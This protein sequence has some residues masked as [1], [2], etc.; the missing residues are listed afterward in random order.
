MKKAIALM[1]VLAM[2]L[3][4]CACGSTSD[5]SKTDASNDLPAQSDKTPDA[6]GTEE[7]NTVTR[8]DLFGEWVNY[9][10]G[11][12]LSI[13]NTEIKY[14]YYSGGSFTTDWTFA[15]LEGDTFSEL[16]LG[17][18]RIVKGE[19]GLQLVSEEYGTFIS[20]D[21]A[22]KRTENESCR[23]GEKGK[24]ALAEISM[25]KYDFAKIIGKE[26]TTR[27]F[28]NDVHYE[29]APD[30]MV[31]MLIYFDLSSLAKEQ[32]NVPFDVNITVDYNNGYLF[33]SLDGNGAYCF[34]DEAN[35][36]Y[37]RYM[38]N[39]G[40]VMELSPLQSGKYFAAIPVAE[41]VSTDTTSPLAVLFEIG[42]KGDTDYTAIRFKVQ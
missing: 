17:E 38:L 7:A 24:G 31:Y 3:A 19:E 35:G 12:T 33:K 36:A 1:V 21:A 16:S 15:S 25:T 26:N 34:V 2:S 28:V 11:D 27:L 9:D 14:S 32:I 30:G 29:S 6:Q 37:Y 39:T 42:E 10:T 40:Y 4:V 5:A 8:E 13:T 23:V 41:I 22:A 18:I 20:S